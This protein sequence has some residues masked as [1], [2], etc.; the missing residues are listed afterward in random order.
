MTDL[1]G[2]SSQPTPLGDRVPIL[3]HSDTRERLRALLF[4]DDMRG[5]GYS[6]FIGRA[7][8]AAEKELSA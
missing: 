3:I 4:D 1:R 8:A 5:V 7:L 6:E 2:P